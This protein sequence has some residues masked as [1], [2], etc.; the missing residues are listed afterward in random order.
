MC[1]A[2]PDGVAARP[3]PAAKTPAGP[4]IPAPAQATIGA[5]QNASFNLTFATNAAADGRNFTLF[6]A[7]LPLGVVLI[8]RRRTKGRKLQAMAVV[9]LVVLIAILLA[10]GGGNSSNNNSPGSPTPA[11]PTAVSATPSGTYTVVIHAVSGSL[12]SATSVQLGIE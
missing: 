2:D 1:F 4:L 9:A 12:E 6:C 11:G 8:P 3:I 7:N 10:C 5:G